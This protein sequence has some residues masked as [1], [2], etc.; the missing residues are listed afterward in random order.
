MILPLLS[1][2]DDGR[3]G[4]LEPGDRVPNGLVVQRVQ[5]R[6]AATRLRDRLDQAERS[7]DAANRFGW[8]VQL[9]R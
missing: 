5:R 1:V 7:R 6:G 8:N 9:K 2:G 4:G 3:P